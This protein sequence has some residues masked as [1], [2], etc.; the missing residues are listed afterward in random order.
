MGIETPQNPNDMGRQGLSPS[1]AAL[2]LLLCVAAVGWTGQAVAM[3]SM[4]HTSAPLHE[5]R[6]L[7]GAVVR[8]V[9]RI[10]RG[11]ETLG[12][13]RQGHRVRVAVRTDR[14]FEVVGHQVDGAPGA[15]AVRVE[16][17]DLPPPAIA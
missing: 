2:V 8:T 11:Q 1:Q 13:L 10:V 14:V 16:L 7:T 3:A 9:K 17:L 12:A 15:R 6:D 5:A 4:G